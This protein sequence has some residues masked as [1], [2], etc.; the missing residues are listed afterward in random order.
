MA[1]LSWKLFSQPT[2]RQEREK[3]S[4]CPSHPPPQNQSTIGKSLSAH[5][6]WWGERPREPSSSNFCGRR[7]AREPLFLQLEQAKLPRDLSVLLAR[8]CRV[9]DSLKQEVQI[10]RI[11]FQMLIVTRSEQFSM[12]E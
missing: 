1:E 9:A 11:N 3:R 7:S 5:R 10:G 4:G 12:A 8:L 2:S 6:R